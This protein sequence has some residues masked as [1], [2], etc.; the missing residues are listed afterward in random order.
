MKTNL[1]GIDFGGINSP[2][3]PLNNKMRCEKN[4]VSPKTIKTTKK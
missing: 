3:P 2:H 4:I 1:F